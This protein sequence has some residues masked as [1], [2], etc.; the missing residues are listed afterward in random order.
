MTSLLTS[1][2]R[3]LVPGN[4]SVSLRVSNLIPQRTL[5][6]ITGDDAFAQYESE[7]TP[8]LLQLAK[9]SSSSDDDDD[10]HLNVLRSSLPFVSSV[11]EIT[12]L[13]SPAI[14]DS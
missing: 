7:P 4:R 13:K 9:R 10:I 1:P 8:T 2:R 14:A 5:E 11:S 3:T 12:S 6:R